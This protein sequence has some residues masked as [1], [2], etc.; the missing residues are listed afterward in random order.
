MTRGRPPKYALDGAS[1]PVV[2]L[3]LDAKGRYHTTHHKPKKYFG[4]DREVAIY[5]FHQWEAKGVKEN[6]S[7]YSISPKS[8]DEVLIAQ[9]QQVSQF[10]YLANFPP[11]LEEPPK[12]W[13]E[14]IT[15]IPESLKF[16]IIKEI[17]SKYSPVEIAEQ[18]GIDEFR[19][20]RNLKAPEPS[21]TLVEVRELFDKRNDISKK[22]KNSCLRKFDRF[23]SIIKCKTLAHI[24]SD[25]IYDFYDD[26]KDEFKKLKT[27]G[28]QNYFKKPITVIKYARDYG[29][30]DKEQL[31]RVYQ[32]CSCFRVSNSGSDDTQAT[33]ISKEDFHK[34]LSISNKRWKAILLLGLNC[35][36]YP[37]DMQRLKQSMFKKVN[38]DTVIDFPR[39]KMK[40]KTGMNARFSVL[41]PETIS[42]VDDYLKEADHKRE[43]VFVNRWRKPLLKQDVERNLVLLVEKAGLSNITFSHLR[44]GTATA[45]YGEVENSVIQLILGHNISNGELKKYIGKKPILLKKCSDIIHKYYFTK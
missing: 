20:F 18:T 17:M 26:T 43:G 19:N 13:P 25:H 6:V 4:T 27:K 9:G 21:M 1:R 16:Q 45:L 2:G 14:V 10:Q 8:R 3:S 23:V 7:S 40:K 37:V 15:H 44:D 41:W 33:P 22:E 11:D 32:L 24:T 39:K 29:R 31:D 42:A 28:L 34:L 38:G 5:K 30:K 12:S 36:F 35:A